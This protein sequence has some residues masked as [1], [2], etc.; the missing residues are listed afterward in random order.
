MVTYYKMQSHAK[1]S[2]KSLE[3][4]QLAKEL[5]RQLSEPPYTN[6]PYRDAWEMAYREVF[7]LVY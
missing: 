7:E 3:I 2:G 1:K 4:N 5:Q 6:V